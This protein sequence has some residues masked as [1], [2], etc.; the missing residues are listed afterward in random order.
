M[1][2]KIQSLD[3]RLCVNDRS[4]AESDRTVISVSGGP[5]RNRSA[6]ESVAARR[7]QT[8]GCLARIR[9]LCPAATKNASMDHRLNSLL[10]AGIQWKQQKTT[11]AANM[12]NPR[13]ISVSPALIRSTGRNCGQSNLISET[14]TSSPSSAWA[15]FSSMAL[16]RRAPSDNGKWNERPSRATPVRATNSILHSSP[17]TKRPSTH[18]VGARGDLH[19]TPVVAA[20]RPAP[21]LGRIGARSLAC[22]ERLQQTAQLP[23][24]SSAAIPP[25]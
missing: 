11:S 5:S 3:L 17:R 25:M 4:E 19:P 10:V 24:R 6:R 8:G 23:V 18:A 21:R 9:T 7:D 14:S 12:V 20:K 1:E 2:R 16:I 15:K 22:L 13:A